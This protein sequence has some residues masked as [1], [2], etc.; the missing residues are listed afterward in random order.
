MY[1]GVSICLVSFASGLSVV[2]LNIY[3]RGVRGAPVPGFLKNIVL[4]KLA[5][6][7]F[8]RFEN[9]CS[10]V[11]RSAT[12]QV[13]Q[14]CFSSKLEINPE[15]GT[16]LDCQ[17][18]WSQN[19]TPNEDRYCL[20]NRHQNSPKFFSRSRDAELDAFESQIV[21][22]LNK[23]HGSI[24]KNDIRLTEQE[25]REQIELE[26]KQT[27]IVLDRVLL[28]IF[29]LITIISTTTILCRSPQEVSV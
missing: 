13:R 14:N 24:D 6:L 16:R 17:W 21:R 23:L 2:T 5:P 18:Q 1:Y 10:S 11:H 25:R 22:I 26:W 28:G 27:S 15:T 19:N 9:A 12:I 8:M 20:Q 4:L 7:V 3:H 29:L